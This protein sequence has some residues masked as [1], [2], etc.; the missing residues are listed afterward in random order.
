M[1]RNLCA[2][3]L[4]GL[5]SAAAA[6]PARCA[7]PAPR[8]KYAPGTV[9]LFDARGFVRTQPAP[10]YWALSPYY[11]P[12]HT[13]TACSAAAAC[14]VVNALR[15]ERRLGAADELATAE[16]VLGTVER[17]AWRDKV[18]DDGPGLTLDELAALLPRAAEAYGVREIRAEVI[19]FPEEPAAALERLR[20]LLAENERSA[21]DVLVANFLQ[22][23]VTGDPEGNVGHFAPV[24]AWDAATRRVLLF[25]PDRRWYEPY[26]VPDEV[27][28]AALRTQDPDA[29]RPR[30]LLR[31][32]RA[33]K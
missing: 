24:G 9:R 1:A 13:E 7:E 33:E 25:D 32:V 3:L 10:D 26:W 16:G 28:L 30:G 17:R 18:A 22:G 31:L 2:A 12:Q 6:L 21:R 20:A 5:L 8:P 4:S 23:T 29:Q 15:A 27:L 19:R 14:M 11:V